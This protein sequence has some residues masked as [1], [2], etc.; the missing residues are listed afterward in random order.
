MVRSHNLGFP[1]IGQQRELKWALEKFWRGEIDADELENTAANLRQQHWQRQI[2]AGID[3]IPVNDFSLYDHVLDMSA[4]LGV[5][6]QRFQCQAEKID[7]AT[8]FRMARGHSTSGTDV[9][10]CEMTKWFDT[11]YHYI[12]PEFEADQDFRIA[13]DKLFAEIKQAQVNNSAIKPVLLGPLTYLWLGKCTSYQ[14]DK[15]NLLERLLPVYQD[16]LLRCQQLGVQWIQFDEPILVLELPQ[17]WQQ[18]F[19]SVYT[20][21]CIKDINI[22][23]AT[24]FGALK[25]NLHL[26]CRLPVAGLHVDLVRAPQQLNS[27]ADQLPAYKILSAGVVDG[28]NIWITE[29]ADLLQRLRG[30]SQRI[31]QNTL[32]IAPSC[33][34]LHC[35]VDL[36]NEQQLDNELKSWLAFAQQKLEETVFIASS[37]SDPAVADSRILEQNTAAVKNRCTS[38]RIH[39]PEVIQRINKISNSDFNRQLDFTQRAQLQ[40]ERLELPVLPTTTIGSFPQTQEIRV[41]RQRFKQGQISQQDYDR[42]ITRQIQLAINKQEQLGLDVLVH[43][44]AERNDM[45]EYFGEQLAGF[46][47]TQNGWVQSYGSRCVKPPIIYG[48]VYRPQAMTLEWT[49]YA[50][51]L[52]Q[53]PVKGMLTGPVTILQWSFVRNDQSRQLTCQQI[54]LALRDEVLDLEKS[55]IHII[56]IDE[57]ALREG[58]P[59]HHSEHSEYLNWAVDCFRLC[60]SGVRNSTQIHT[61]MCYAQF[62]DIIEW[63]ARLDA[64]VITIE[65]SRSHMELLDA[66][67]TF[68]YPN[69]IGPGTYDIHSPRIPQQTEI[70]DLLRK[71]SQY[72]PVERLWVNPDCGLKTRTWQETET[73]LANMVSA[74]KQLRQE[75]V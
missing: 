62:N 32:W 18:A 17:A 13:S 14:G 33:S 37:L 70:V 41:A 53:Q 21:L 57:P 3:L 15:L 6:P 58:L 45:V 4:L 8:Y 12:V 44:E 25:N 42:I 9:I 51:S 48:D 60:A 74:A 50:Q 46:A 27:V 35:P 54:A 30:L 66:F 2:K 43:G 49:C 5:V 40:Q 29:L 67:K 26:S 65:T 56:Q 39:N 1:R 36:N 20:R 28:R 7:L 22:L 69:A 64:D 63:I 52:T 16:I 73:A 59:L 75:L 23:L 68:A 72:I 61:H 24:Y 34:L 11:N 71:A 10:A 38:A 55:A 19:E 47:F 31:E